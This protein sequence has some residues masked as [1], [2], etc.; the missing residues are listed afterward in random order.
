MSIKREAYG[1][2]PLK[3]LDGKSEW[4]KFEGC[5]P[6]LYNNIVN[7]KILERIKLMNIKQVLLIFK[8]HPSQVE[9]GTIDHHSG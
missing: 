3:F 2:H 7:R 5:G 1:L 4:V 6:I 9:C 8:K